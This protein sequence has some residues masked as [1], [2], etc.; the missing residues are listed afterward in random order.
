MRTLIFLFTILTIMTIFIGCK[1]DGLKLEEGIYSGT[2]TVTYSSGKETGI[3]TIEFKDSKFTCTANSN[4]TPAGGSGTYSIDNGV[5]TFNDENVWTA[6][7]DWNLILSGQYEY[8]FDGNILKI[9][10]DKTNV[11]NYEYKLEK[12]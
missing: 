6:D 9:S 4:R 5:I 12:E 11:G 8:S 1:K 2:F 10:A 3:T 7:F